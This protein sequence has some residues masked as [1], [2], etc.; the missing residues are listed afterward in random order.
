MTKKK[1]KALREASTKNKI[2]KPIKA[3]TG[4]EI[5]LIAGAAGLVGS[6]ASKQ[7]KS[8]TDPF[9]KITDMNAQK[10]ISENTNAAKMVQSDLDP[11]TSSGESMVKETTMDPIDIQPA[12]FGPLN[13]FDQNED[14]EKMKKGGLARGIGKAIKGT[15]FKGIF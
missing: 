8:T 10:F 15:S 2:I 3:L 4:L 11:V 9:K 7:K 1:T 6:Q 5:A 14:T 12:G 13:A